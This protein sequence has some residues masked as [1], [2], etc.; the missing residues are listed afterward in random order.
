MNCGLCQA[1]S[2]YLCDTFAGK[3]LATLYGSSKTS[4]LPSRCYE[5]L[6][7]KAWELR[8]SGDDCV[9]S[10]PAQVGLLWDCEHDFRQKHRQSRIVTCSAIPLDFL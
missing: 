9:G 2:F 8:K 5:Q 6:F 10:D 7:I 4:P 1:S 3:S